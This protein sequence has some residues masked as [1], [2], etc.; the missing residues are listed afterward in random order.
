MSSNENEMEGSN[1]GVIIVGSANQDLVAYTPVLPTRGQTVMGTSFVTSCGGK[2]ANQAV[3]AASIGV[4]PNGVSM[5]CRVGDDSFG[6]NLLSNFRRVNVIYDEEKVIAKGSAKEGDEGEETSSSYHTGVAPILVDTQS[7]DN[8]IVVAPGANYALAPSDVKESILS[9]SKKPSVVVTQLEIK[10]ESALEA[11]RTGREVNAITILNTAP[12]PEDWEMSDE[13]YQLADI[14]IP[15]ETELRVI[16]GRPPH[17]EEGNKDGGDVENTAEIEMAKELLNKG[18]R[19]AVIVTLGARG[20]MIVERNP[21]KSQEE[22]TVTFVDAPKDLPC[23]SLP[24]V[25]TVGAGDAFCGALSAYLD[26]GLMLDEA[27]TKACG[28]A[29]MSVRKRGAQDSYPTAKDLP[30]MLRV[31]GSSASGEGKPIISFVTGNKNKLAEVKRMLLSSEKVP[32]EIESRDIDLPELQ[33]DPLEVAREKCK[34]AALEI[35]GPVITEDTSLCFNALNGMP[36]PYIKWFLE[37]CGHDGLN[38]MLTGF[39]D[40]SA[41]AQTVVAFCAG[42][43]K[44]VQLFDGRTHGRIVRPRGPLNFGWDPI[45]EPDVGEEVAKTYAEMSKDEKDAISHRGRSMAKFKKFLVDEAESICK[46]I[47]A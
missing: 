30:D 33:G 27:A 20:A 1:A 42:P 44:E 37:K 31:E 13:F 18:V 4:S 40:K 5:V 21:D 14:V 38:D 32:F 28:V 45:F 19:R 26:A 34:L 39:E 47:G 25:D 24:V 15:N 11:L 2:G 9:S 6:Q 12:A 8:V 35:N 43:G 10:P 46:S 3:A 16:C 23:R 29:S 41:Y 17:D 7:G 36:G 22:P